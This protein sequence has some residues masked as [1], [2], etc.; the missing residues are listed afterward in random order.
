MTEDTFIICASIT[1]RGRMIEGK[2]IRTFALKDLDASSSSF[3][4]LVV[5]CTAA[6]GQEVRR[7]K[8]MRYGKKIVQRFN[9]SREGCDQHE[10]ERERMSMWE[11]VSYD[12]L[13]QISRVQP[14][15][16]DDGL[17]P[18]RLKYE[19]DW[20][21]R[22]YVVNVGR[23]VKI[24]ECRYDIV[25]VQARKKSSILQVRKCKGYHQSTPE[26]KAILVSVSKP[27]PDVEPV[28]EVHRRQNAIFNSPP[29]S[30]PQPS[31]NPSHPQLPSTPNSPSSFH[32]SSPNPITTLLP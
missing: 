10:E 25:E 13:L 29:L 27:W 28:V 17:H 20:K 22:R 18:H 19:S 6:R 7:I 1:I 3:F 24:F 5:V 11:A 4:P 31:N 21:G 30:I 2:T 23:M 8:R 14:P 15:I 32:A 9:G 12:R 16:M 26:D